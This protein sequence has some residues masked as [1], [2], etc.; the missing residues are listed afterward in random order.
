[1]T[2]IILAGGKSS[3]MGA[4]KAFLCRPGSD[5]GATLIFAC[6]KTLG[7]IADEIIISA[8]DAQK[9]AGL[10]V[11]VAGDI[12]TGAGPLGGIHSG[13]MN[14]GSD[15]NFVCACDMPFIDN[16][17]VGL[18]VK[19]CA[20][21]DAAVPLI[22]GQ[23]EPLHAV[24]SK[25]CAAAAEE[26]LEAGIFS[27]RSFIEKIDAAWVKEEEFLDA[28]IDRSSFKNVNTPEEYRMLLNTMPE[29]SGAGNG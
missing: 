28:G 29:N 5:S 4:D 23:P 24:Y 17:A 3:R 25:K 16:K 7:C 9:F 6:V 20:G 14:S 11:R 18:L 12:Y 1:M 19:R 8:N 22:N 27:V 10:G 26:Q 2:A 15:Y 13:L 21:R